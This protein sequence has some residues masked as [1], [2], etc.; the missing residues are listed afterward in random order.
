MVVVVAEYI[1][2]GI[3]GSTP[4]DVSAIGSILIPS[5]KRAGYKVETAEEGTAALNM[6]PVFKPDVIQVDIMLP[7]MDG[8]EVCR[9]VRMYR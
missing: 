3:S 7:G 4:A 2:S 6:L 1:F 8:M 9:E 5:M